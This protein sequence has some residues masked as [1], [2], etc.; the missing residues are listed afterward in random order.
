MNSRQLA[1]L[2]TILVMVGGAVG[3]AVGIA[4]GREDVINLAVLLMTVYF[5]TLGLILFGGAVIDAVEVRKD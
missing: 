4:T 1:L 2:V 5:M 3:I